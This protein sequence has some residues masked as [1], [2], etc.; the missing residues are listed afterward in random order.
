MDALQAYICSVQLD[1]NHT[2][3]WSN[4]G[5]LYEYFNQPHDALKCFMNAVRGKGKDRLTYF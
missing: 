2:A 4:L 1:K 3:A 5:A